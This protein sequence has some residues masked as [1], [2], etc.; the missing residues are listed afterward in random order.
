MRRPTQRHPAYKLIKGAN[1]FA[2]AQARRLTDGWFDEGRPEPQETPGHARG[3]TERA[4][5]RAVTDTWEERGR[6]PT[7]LAVAARLHTSESTLKRAMKDLKLGS[8]PPA[9]LDD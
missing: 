2:D 9:R 4:I 6:R 7:Q 8:W 3:L 5:R 1:D